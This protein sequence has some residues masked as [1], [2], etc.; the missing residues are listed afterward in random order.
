MK[1]DLHNHTTL[2]N[3][4]TGEIDEYIKQAIKLNCE[5]YG[6]SDHAPMKY[7]EAYRMNFAQMNLYESMVLKA[8]EDFKDKIKILLGYEVD[9]LDG[10]IDERVLARDVDYFIGSVHFIGGWGF[11]NPEFIG[12]YSNKNIDDIWREYFACIEQLAKCGKFDIVGHFDLMKLFNFMPKTDIRILAKDAI[13]EI[14]KANL[15]LEINSAGL[16]KPAAEQYPSVELLELVYEAQIPISFGSDA[17][18]P[19]Q[20]GADNGLCENL[21]R[22]M[23]FNKC[24]SY[25]KRDRYFVKF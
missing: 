25:E 4:A 22:K 17:H 18:D 5:I 1:V 14:K 8:K 24:V 7:D 19:L 9:F 23:G 12:E 2:C 10:F 11:D 20:V 6:I 3:H 15:A 13:K 16:R 21:A